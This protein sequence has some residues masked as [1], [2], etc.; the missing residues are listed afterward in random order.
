MQGVC[1]TATVAMVCE[2][3]GSGKIYSAA[4]PPHNLAFLPRYNQLFWCPCKGSGHRQSG[5]EVRSLMQGRDRI[6][7]P[8]YQTQENPQDKV[9]EQSQNRQETNPKGSLK[10]ETW[11]R[12]EPGSGNRRLTKAG[13]GQNCWLPCSLLPQPGLN[14]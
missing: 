14:G 6:Q 12:V 3:L 13:Q 4:L 8:N 11:N 5:P 9:H 7:E 10:P 1:T 2:S